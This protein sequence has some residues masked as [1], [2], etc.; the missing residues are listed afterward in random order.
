[1]R[2]VVVGAALALLPFTTGLLVAA[3]L[4]VDGAIG[5]FLAAYVVGWACVVGPALMLSPFRGLTAGWMVAAEVG[6]A[7][8]AAAWWFS[9]GRAR[10]VPAVR[11]GGLRVDWS[12]GLL[13]FAVG[14]ALL[15]DVAAVVALAP[16]TY[17]SLTY[18]LPRAAQ[19]LEH[20]GWYWIENAATA[21]LNVFP[22]GAEFGVLHTVMAFRSDRLVELPQLL[23]LLA[24]LGGIVG[25][26]RRVG[27]EAAAALFAALLFATFSVVA[28]EATTTQND[29]VVTSFG[30]AAAYFVLSE[31]RADVALA[32]LALALGLATKTTVALILPVVVM[33]AVAASSRRRL[34]VLAGFATLFS[35]LLAVPA[36]ARN[37]AQA[38]SLLSGDGVDEHRAELTL[39]GLMATTFRLAYKFLD[40]SGFEA[41]AAPAFFLLLTAGLSLI[42]VPTYAR[43]RGRRVAS[44]GL[45][46]AAGLLLCSPVLIA[47][48]PALI[49][50][51]VNLL[52]V[53]LNPS[54]ATVTEFDWDLVGAPDEDIS[55]FGPLGAS[56]L[57]AAAIVGVRQARGRPWRT[58]RLALA[59]SIP[60]A[61]V[62]VAV[63]YKYNAWLGRFM[64][65]PVAL[66]A[67]LLAS[68]HRHRPV[69]LAAAAL[70]SLTLALAL[71]Y[72]V[73][74]PSGLGAEDSA[75]SR[76]REQ[77][78]TQTRGR[79]SRA[80]TAYD[81]LVARDACVGALFGNNDIVYPLYDER[82]DRRVVYLPQHGALATAD[83]AALDWIVVSPVRRDATS[84]L[85]ES[86]E[87]RAKELSHY[88]LVL[89]RVRPLRACKS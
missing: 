38:G 61:I 70:G 44:F 60:T 9:S 66:T 49:R 85:L 19:W 16:N 58:A 31:R 14:A 80:F 56:L 23:A 36:Y 59:L 4:R 67:P 48:S 7:L 22:P 62:L 73:Q 26:A 42:L 65:A 76:T 28:L 29:L 33:L 78:F 24:T 11:L 50:M 68:L 47:L 88:L 52:S 74:K 87:W 13:G 43:A 12:V 20:G 18:H 79:A 15:Y 34:L 32:G 2:D 37:I 77:T 86:G 35:V 64:I 57:L 69:A 72:S 5:R 81:E 40:L 46:V 45:L 17:D 25:L 1:M 10:L 75:W 89:R 71:V 54:E 55:Y 53:G 8:A 21:R 82:W 84:E 6:L 63:E 83:L 3:A 30:A 39:E 27:F 41:V 51:P